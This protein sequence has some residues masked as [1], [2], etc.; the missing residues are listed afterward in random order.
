MSSAYEIL[1][2]LFKYK[3]PFSI[4]Q[5]FSLGLTERKV[6]FVL[7]ILSLIKSKHAVLNKR[8]TS[9]KPKSVTFKD[10]GDIDG[11]AD[12]LG[13]KDCLTDKNMFSTIN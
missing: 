8:S 10:E 13:T 3:P 5:F 12:L 11:N 6:A 9:L 2:L 1:G 7:D 4:E